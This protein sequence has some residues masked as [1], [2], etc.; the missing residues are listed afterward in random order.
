MIEEIHAL[1][2]LIPDSDIVEDQAVD[3]TVL[4]PP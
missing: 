4:H 2:G 3:Q 1:N